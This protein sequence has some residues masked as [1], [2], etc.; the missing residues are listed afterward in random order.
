MS[1]V[2]FVSTTAFASKAT[3]QLLAAGRRLEVD[4]FLATPALN[5]IRNANNIFLPLSPNMSACLLSML[6]RCSNLDS[7]VERVDVNS[8]VQSCWRGDREHIGRCRA[9]VGMQTLSKWKPGGLLGCLVL[10]TAGAFWVH[11][12]LSTNLPKAHLLRFMGSAPSFMLLASTVQLICAG[13]HIVRKK[14]GARLCSAPVF[15]E[16][17]FHLT[18]VHILGNCYKYVRAGYL[19]NAV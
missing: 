10:S 7:S 18:L 13:S 8:F 3:R 4:F 1:A 19:G 14:R 16:S 6:M 15:C 17:I 12:M 11:G 5:V 2:R 9:G